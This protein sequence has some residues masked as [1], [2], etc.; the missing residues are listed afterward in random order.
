[1]GH[2]QA[3]SDFIH[4]DDIIDFIF[5]LMDNVHDGSGWNIGSGKLTSFLEIIDLFT[6]FAGYKPTIKPLI[7][8]PMGVHSRYADMTKVFS[9]FDW[10]P[11]VSLEEGMYRV[12]K[13]QLEKLNKNK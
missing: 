2:R 10:R 5:V 4:I 3:S 7:D 1:M 11:K 6:K 9:T 13:A 8:K 12:Y